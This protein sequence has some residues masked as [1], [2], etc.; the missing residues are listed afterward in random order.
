MFDE[1]GRSF[2][3]KRK[4]K[5]GTIGWRCTCRSGTDWC[6]AT[7]LQKGENFIF[8]KN[9]HTCKAKLDKS[10]HAEV[11]QE[12]KREVKSNIY[13]STAQVIEPIFT[14]HFEKDPERDFPMLANV[15]RV[16]RRA[17]HQSIPKNL[18]DMEFDMGN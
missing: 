2:G 5:N 9:P 1:K 7:V 16:A 18:L 4:C 11:I 15:H 6:R 3:V 10:L 14:K 13:A 12:V 17:K 8:G